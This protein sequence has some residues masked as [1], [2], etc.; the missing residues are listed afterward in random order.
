MESI[1]NWA[2]YYQRKGVENMAYLYFDAAYKITFQLDIA[3]VLIYYSFFFHW[4]SLLIKKIKMLIYEESW[5]N[6]FVR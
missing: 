1:L 5:N 6:S 3:F 2:L 4:S